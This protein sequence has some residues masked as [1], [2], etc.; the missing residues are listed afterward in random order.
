[1]Q[2][3]DKG[4]KI[5]ILSR[6]KGDGNGGR[7][8]Q[9]WNVVGAQCRKIIMADIRTDIKVMAPEISLGTTNENDQRHWKCHVGHQGHPIKKT[10]VRTEGH[11]REDV[12]T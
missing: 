10:L 9:Y 2:S 3:R 1:M 12:Q 6:R 8:E 11:Q 5:G 7:K 4:I